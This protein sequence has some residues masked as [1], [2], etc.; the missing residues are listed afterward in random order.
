MSPVLI[1]VC[2]LAVLLALMAVRVPVV[3]AMIVAGVGGIGFL[4]SWPA[5]FSTLFTETWGTLTYVQLTVISLFVLMGNIASASGMSRDLYNLAYAMIGHFRGGLAHAPILGCTGFAALPGSSVASALTLGRVALPEMKRF[6]YDPKFANGSVAAGGTMGI[7]IPP[8][9]GFIIYAILTE[10][11]IGRLFLA[12][13]VPGLI[14]SACFMLTIWLMTLLRPQ[15]GPA[16]ER[17]G[18]ADRLRFLVRGR[19][20][21]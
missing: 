16:G 18:F 4:N 6:D 15:I 7:L 13:V 19:R 17:F 10:G 8:S 3:F 2:G 21:C 5:A 1:G 20:S 14:L 12:G 9:T 11:S